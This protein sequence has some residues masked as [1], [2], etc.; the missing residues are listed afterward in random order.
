MNNGLYISICNEDDQ[1]MNLPHESD[2]PVGDPKWSMNN[3][4]LQLWVK[5]NYIGLGWKFERHE[6]LNF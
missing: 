4:F 6:A 2:E 1:F 3:E 5:T